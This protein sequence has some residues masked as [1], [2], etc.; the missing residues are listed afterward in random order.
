MTIILVEDQKIVALDIRLQ[1]ESL[2]HELLAICSTGE[3]CLTYLKT[4][5]PDLILMDIHLNGGMSGIETANQIHQNYTIPILFLTA[6]PDDSTLSEIKNAGFYGYINKPFKQID[7]HTEIVFTLDRYRKYNEIKKHQDD[8]HSAWVETE[9]FYRQIVNNVSDIIYRIDLKGYFT[10]VN[11]SAVRQTGF[12][13]EELLQMPFTALIHSDA[14]EKAYLFFKE[15]YESGTEFSTAE[16]PMLRKD[17][18]LVWIG[19]EVHLLMSNQQISGFQVIARDITQERDFKEH[20]IVAKANA[21][22][23]AELK[24]QF[25][26]NMSHE[27]RTPLN[28][29]TGIIH[30][31]EKTPLTHKQQIYI[32]AILSSSNQLMG[33]INDVLDLSKIDAGKLEMEA[34]TFDLYALVD[35]VQAIFEV[36]TKEKGIQ[37]VFTV[38]Q[39]IPQ[40]LIGDPVRLNQILYNLIGNAV[41]F[42]DTGRVEV[43]LRLMKIT[44][45]VCSILFQIIDTGI[46]MD[47][48]VVVRIFDTFTQAESDTTRKFGGTGLGLSIVKKLVNLLGGTI[49]V[50]SKLHIGST[51][52]I[53][54]PFAIGEELQ[55]DANHASANDELFSLEGIKVLLVED[56]PINQLVTKDLLE[57]EKVEVRVA[58]NGQIAL[59]M[60]EDCS[61]DVI[62]MDMQMPVLDGYQTMRIIRNMEDNR[63]R[64][65]PI[66]ALTANAIESEI[67]KCYDSGANAYVAKPF[68]PE[69]LFEAIHAL[70]PQQH[71]DQVNNEQLLIN[72]DEFAHFLNGN[73]KLIQKTLEQLK[74]AFTDDAR[75]FIDLLNEENI[76]DLKKVAHRMK[77]NF[78]ILGLVD[79]AEISRLIEVGNSEDKEQIIQLGEQLIAA[80]PG[81]NDQLSKQLELPST[82]IA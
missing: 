10:Y 14:Q 66:I 50:Q 6:Y 2:G 43:A 53:E 1:V 11:P 32:Q 45:N 73:V 74:I 82:K 51:F 79:L 13:E 65:I 64:N 16:F 41:K 24:S 71:K 30:L 22:K 39:D 42:T 36:K 75:V 8:S 62:L 56:N 57:A 72:M 80:I 44:D 7:L 4:E 37:M 9:E 67:Q 48:K 76:V 35:S 17:G 47:E 38:P 26:A 55:I 3:E 60:M 15:L 58:S 77:P 33:I 54:L 40:F 61:C 46:G 63:K 5:Q 70:L 21:E 59:E 68:R 29:I 78:A 20:L 81:V 31:L 69:V 49:E 34:T 12:S 27:I 28:G 52:F 19:Q 25:L 23:T 18:Q